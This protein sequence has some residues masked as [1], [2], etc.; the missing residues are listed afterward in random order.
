MTLSDIIKRAMLQKAYDFLDRDPTVNFPKLLDWLEKLDHG[1]SISNQ[2]S[3]LKKIADAP[4]SNWYQLI[5]SLW[6]DVDGEV[7]KT[8]FTNVVINA[9]VLD[10]P[11]L[12]ENR[13]R[14]QCNIPWVVQME[15][16]SGNGAELSFDE[17]DGVIEE[18]ENLGIR[19]YVLTG[20][21]NG[22]RED[23]VALCN[24]HSDCEFLVVTERADINESFAAEMLRVKNLIPFL[25]LAGPNAAESMEGLRKELQLLRQK[26]LPFGMLCVCERE[27]IEALSDEAF[28]DELVSLGTKIVGF[29]AYMPVGKSGDPH[30]IIM[31]EQRALFY[32]HVRAFRQT[33]PIFS[34]DFR[35]DGEFV[36]G[37]IGGG[38]RYCRISASG[39]VEPCEEVRYSD[40][41]I[42]RKGMLEAFRSPLFLAFKHSQ[43]FRENMFCSCPVM[44]APDQLKELEKQ[45]ILRSTHPDGE[46]STEV[47]C[48]KCKEYAQAW[49]PVAARLWRE[50]SGGACEGCGSQ[51]ENEQNHKNSKNGG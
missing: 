28:F 2:L 40:S 39:D 21:L 20:S 42:R 18:C 49:A 29:S 16:A 33:K 4:A 13:K 15:I 22:R 25:K 30:R 1:G 44:E 19:I 23:L 7:R 24:K 10:N 27:N 38:K 48:R 5:E 9:C 31:P 11:K 17:M 37:C 26:Q 35:G 46:E 8:L 36:G 14:Y 43:P 50:R 51:H 6:K 45:A 32:Q 41:N 34:I 12:N 3:L 47:L